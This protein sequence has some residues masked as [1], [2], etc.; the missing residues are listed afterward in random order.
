MPT[1]VSPARAVFDRFLAASVENRWDDLADLY[2]EDVTLE[3]PFTL[4]GVPRVT[5]GREELRRRF[6]AAAGSRRI[7]EAG[8]VVVHETTDPSVLV[9]EFDLHQE[10]RGEA[11]AVSY[12]MVLTVRDGRIAHSRDYTDTAAAAERIKAWSRAGS[13]AG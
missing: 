6:R 8:N 4:P 1:T 9:A 12:V 10:E 13:T 7:V 3:M 11:F 2:A 5:K